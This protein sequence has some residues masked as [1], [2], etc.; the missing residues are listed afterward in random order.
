MMA[1]LSLWL[2]K[3]ILVVLLAVFLDL[4]LPNGVMQRYV[5][6]VM[7][8][9]ILATMLAPITSFFHSSWSP[10]ALLAADLPLQDTSLQQILE[11]GKAMQK[12]QEKQAEE[13]WKKRMESSLKQQI[14]KEYPV[15]V[16]QVS[17]AYTLN[18]ENAASY[19]QITGVSLILAKKEGSAPAVS[20][21]PVQP[22]QIREG[23]QGATTGTFMPTEEMKT[24]E[25]QICKEIANMWQLPTSSIILR[26]EKA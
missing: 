25:Q 6:V 13:E 23:E 16:E 17:L 22:V 11:Q 21:Q 24:W 1:M 20:I 9:V 5:R 4:L 18:Q 8:F 3:I 26:W 12:E 7:G 2:K 19:P 14:E 10:N 15:T